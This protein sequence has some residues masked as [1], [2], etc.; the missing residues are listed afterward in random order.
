MPC[1]SLDD[2]AALLCEALGLYSFP[3]VTFDFGCRRERLHRSSVEVRSHE[4]MR[5]VEQC[6]GELL[7]SRDPGSPARNPRESSSRS[8]SD[9]RSGDRARARGLMPPVR[10]MNRW[11]DLVEHPTAAAAMANVSP[12]KTRRWISK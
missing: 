6:V 8:A 4:A 2:Y 9:S 11:M 10:A 7:R 1:S 5:D 12:S 3:P